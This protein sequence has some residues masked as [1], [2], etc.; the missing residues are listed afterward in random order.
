MI[1]NSLLSFLNKDKISEL[2]HLSALV[3]GQTGPFFPQLFQIGQQRAVTLL[4]HVC[5]QAS[6]IT[7][8]KGHRMGSPCILYL[9]DPL[10][11]SVLHLC[12]QIKM[13]YWTI[14]FLKI[15][16]GVIIYLFISFIFKYG[17][18]KNV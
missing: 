7:E 3:E 2:I 12:P 11:N 9:V 4:L 18:D 8:F 5:L 1:T 10:T 14:V 13:L 16:E 6:T 17:K 15:Q